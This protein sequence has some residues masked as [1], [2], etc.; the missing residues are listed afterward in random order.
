MALI[1]CRFIDLPTIIDSRGNLSIIEQNIQVPFNIK[2]IY[3]LYDVPSDAVRGSHAH[4]TLH[5][6]IVALSGSFDV[7]LNDGVSSKRFHLDRAY[8]GLYLT[9]MLWR[10]LDNFSTGSVCMVVASEVYDETDY[11]RSYTDYQS[12]VNAK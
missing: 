9:P 12:L 4:K 7:L 2:R 6:F 1:D 3:Y 10:T 11:I 5:Q 8:R